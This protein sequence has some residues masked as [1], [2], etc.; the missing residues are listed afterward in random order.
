MR[1]AGSQR[2]ALSHAMVLS[3]LAGLAIL[4]LSPRNRLQRLITELGSKETTNHAAQSLLKL[5]KANPQVRIYLA[6]ELPP[7]ISKGPPASGPWTNAVSLA[8]ELKISRC[9]KALTKWISA[10]PGRGTVT[11]GQ[12]ASLEDQ[13]AA[14]ALA[15]IGDPAVPA[16]AGTLKDGNL[17]ERWTAALVL[18]DVGTPPAISALK[19][20]LVREADPDLRA[21]I[22]KILSR[23]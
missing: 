5:G 17:P 12:T 2:E 16:V 1:Q 3:T 4:A 23:S 7:I 13:P 15:Q 8:G 21:F 19:G 18:E 11:L 6:E 10:R 9:S 20:H 22:R 14:K